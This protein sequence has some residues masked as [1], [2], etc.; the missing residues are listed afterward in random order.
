MWGGT[1]CANTQKILG[2]VWGGTLCANTQKILGVVCGGVHSAQIP[3]RY[4]TL[5]GG[6]HC[7]QTPR[8]YWTLCGV[9]AMGTYLEKVAESTRPHHHAEHAILELG[10]SLTF[11][12]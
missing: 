7:M 2:V 3:R 9:C 4:W 8:R 12:E 5:C 11:R 1:L 6:V 10:E